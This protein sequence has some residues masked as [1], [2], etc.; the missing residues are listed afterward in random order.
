M[1]KSSIDRAIMNLLSR[2]NHQDKPYYGGKRFYAYLLMSM[3]KF[4]D[5]EG[6]PTAAVSI[7]NTINLYIN[8]K[9]FESLTEQQRVE[10]L[11]HECKHIFNFHQKRY[12]DLDEKDMK[13][14]NI[15]CDAAINEPLTSL[16]E[17][18]VTANSLKKMIPDLKNNESSEYYYKK[19]KEYREEN[20][21]KNGKGQKDIEENGETIDDHSKWGESE[22]N[23]D[24]NEENGYSQIDE[25]KKQVIKRAMQDAV[26]KCE[27]RGNVPMTY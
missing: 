18:G 24:G 12:T 14:W 19:L 7:T 3:R 9:F 5:V 22:E 11:E 4:Y 17:M 1:S 26:E 15:A 27:G 6:I 8:T 20:G 13:L 25:V 21:G 16:H 2:A 10:V 23:T